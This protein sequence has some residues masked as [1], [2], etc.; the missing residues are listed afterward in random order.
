MSEE[1]ETEL[2]LEQKRLKEGYARTLVSWNTVVKT[3]GMYSASHPTSLESAQK[4]AVVLGDILA[5]R[6]ECAIQHSDGLFVAED[7][8]FI[9]ESLMFYDLLRQLERRKIHSVVFLPGVAAQELIQLG[10]HLQPKNADSVFGS[11]HIRTT[12]EGERAPA[13][14][15]NAIVRVE[16]IY[17]EWLN[18]ADTIFSKLTDEQTLIGSELSLRLDQLIDAVHQNPPVW[19]GVLAMPR[20]APVNTRHAIDSMVLAIYVG[21]QLNY[22]LATIKTLAIAALLHDIGRFFLPADFKTGHTVSPEDVPFAQLHSRDGAS[23]LAG[24]PGLPMSVVRCALEHHIGTDGQGYPVLPTSHNLH[25][26]SKIISLVDFV[27]WG[28]VSDTCYHRPVPLHRRIRSLIRRSGTQFDPLLVKILVPFFGVYPPGTR[29][30]LSSG[31]IGVVMLPDPRNIL[32]PSV[33]I[34]LGNGRW[35]FRPLNQANE[36]EDLIITGISGKA[37]EFSKLIPHVFSFP[38]APKAA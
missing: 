15:E 20:N 1:K 38:T 27:S 29:V 10:S 34:P 14:N 37:P 7:F 13:K 36:Q 32:R 26:F 11:E 16:K 21:L 28:T 17:D 23:F 35:S 19:A 9:E 3:I 24:V 30:Q 33:A 25:F 2:Q 5:K 6:F 18:A 22:D 31:Q 12:S 8:F 4:M